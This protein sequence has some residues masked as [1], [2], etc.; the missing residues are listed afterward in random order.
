[1]E[2]VFY[3]TIVLSLNS[4]NQQ[5]DTVTNE[6]IREFGGEWT[7]EKLKILKLYLDFYTTAMKNTS[8]KLGYIDPFA[9]YGTWHPKDGGEP[10]K[11]TPLIALETQGRPFD[12][13]VFNDINPSYIDA[14]Y[15]RIKDNFPHKHTKFSCKDANLFLERFCKNQDWKELR[16]VTFLDPFATEVKW[17]SLEAIAQT[18]AIDTL[19]LF[20]ISAL[21]RMLRRLRDPNLP[22]RHVNK[23]SEIF[24]DESWKLIYDSSFQE[25][26][27]NASKERRGVQQ[28][29]LPPTELEMRPHYSI[30]SYAYR[31]RLK[32]IFPRIADA[33]VALKNNNSPLF[34]IMFVVGN[35]SDKAQGVAM[36]GAEH[37]I[38]NFQNV[39]I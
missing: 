9:G 2:Y 22:H 21:S 4:N 25:E 11:G 34:E 36:R 27:E 14:L 17:S 12:R 1:M 33:H 29:L 24:G 6:P 26:F 28:S 38:R 39:Q 7:D 15:K 31:K 18:K 35:P 30:I 32:T 8:F 13:L 5:G 37:I 16:A 3:G 23:M 20:P 10:R 19:M